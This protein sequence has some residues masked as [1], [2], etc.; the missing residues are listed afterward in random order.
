MRTVELLYFLLQRFASE[1]EGDREVQMTSVT[2]GD[3]K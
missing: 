3:W 1:K 2:S